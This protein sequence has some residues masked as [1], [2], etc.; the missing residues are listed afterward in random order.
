[1]I[2][3]RNLLGLFGISVAA[4]SIPLQI[5]KEKKPEGFLL[6]LSAKQRW[7]QALRG[8]PPYNVTPHT[9][10]GTCA[11]GIVVD[12]HTLVCQNDLGSPQA[13]DLAEIIENMPL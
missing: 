5:F 1:M 13:R 10:Y 7:I 3:R 6:P 12:Q 11:L 4:P 2:S 9:T 8:G